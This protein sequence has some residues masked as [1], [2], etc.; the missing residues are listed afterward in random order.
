MHSDIEITDVQ[1]RLEPGQGRVAYQ[2]LVER[3]AVSITS[4]AFSKLAQTALG[5]M[6]PRL[7][8][9]VEL[10][11]AEL[12]EGG[13]EVVAKVKKSILKADLRVRLAFSIQDP[14]TIRVRIAELDGPAWIPTQFVLEN[15][16]N[17]AA[18]RPGFTRVPEDDRAV[19]VNPAAVIAS[20][21]IPLRLASPGAWRIDPTASEITIGYGPVV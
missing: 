16:L 13:A 9:D 18:A 7:P 21:G 6:G 8:V 15:A 3:L 19:D 5:V 12:T 17:V 1:V 2:P 4:G 20:R 10:S 11:S 14:A